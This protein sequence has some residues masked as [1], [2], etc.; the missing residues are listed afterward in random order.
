MQHQ[1]VSRDEWIAASAEL[2]V[3]EK[4]HTHASDA[5]AAARPLAV[6][7]CND[8]DT[9]FHNEFQLSLWDVTTEPICV[10]SRT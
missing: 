9:V 8:D 7:T 2:L 10:M 6:P 1:I 4:E 3:R 5:L